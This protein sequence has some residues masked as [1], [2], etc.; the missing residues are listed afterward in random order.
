M[1][2]DYGPDGRI[3]VACF[4]D[5]GVSRIDAA[6]GTPLGPFVL[7][8]SGGL[9]N[10]RSVAFGPDGD[11]Y[12]SSTTGEVLRYDGAT[13]AFVETFV[14]AGGNG[15]G[16]VDPYGLVFH[17]G[18][19]YVASYFPSEVKAFDAATGAFVSTFVPS[20]GGGLAGPTALAFGA[21]GD[22]YAASRDDDTIR[23]YD[24]ATGAFVE[25]FV[26]A[27]SGGLDGPFDLVFGSSGGPAAVPS[28]GVAGRL[29]LAAAL[30]AA[31]GIAGRVGSGA[32]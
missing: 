26:A 5:N 29:A 10:P 19:L 13:G 28:L 31:V 14:D 30:L 20:G 17:G 18:R 4:G 27:G 22:L 11:L 9:S 32:A 12:V 24:G 3:Y 23:R 6:T 1:D 8:G 25:V 2:L 7:G 16:P 21:D 15:G